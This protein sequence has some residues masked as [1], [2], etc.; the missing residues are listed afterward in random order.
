[1]GHLR[2]CYTLVVQTVLDLELLVFTSEE[3]LVRIDAFDGTISPTGNSLLSLE[4]YEAL[5]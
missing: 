4:I 3:S 2:P 1:M 5:A